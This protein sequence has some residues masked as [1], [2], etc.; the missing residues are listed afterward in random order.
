M[1]LM[2]DVRALPSPDTAPIMEGRCCPHPI[3]A[4]WELRT[5][6]GLLGLEGQPEPR[7][8]SPARV[9]MWAAQV[10]SGFTRLTLPLFPHTR[11]SPHFYFTP[12]S[13]SIFLPLEMCGGRGKKLVGEGPVQSRSNA[14]FSVALECCS[15]GLGR[16]ATTRQILLCLGLPPSSK[17]PA[18]VFLLGLSILGLLPDCRVLPPLPSASPF[19]ISFSAG[20]DGAAPAPS[21]HPPPGQPSISLPLALGSSLPFS[22]QLLKS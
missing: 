18:Q 6:V 9:G 12:S 16:C 2:G 19:T 10:S 21:C 3:P 11:L 20:R 5:P 15:K 22:C 14:F 7:C 17:L 1:R 4:L 13:S 8:S